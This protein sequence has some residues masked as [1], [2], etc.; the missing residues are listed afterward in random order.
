MSISTEAPRRGAAA[1]E[2]PAGRWR[3]VDIVVA[4]VIAVA[5]GAVFQVWNLAWEGARPA[6]LFFP[7]CRAPCTGSG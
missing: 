4:A 2:L 7:P 1:T 3:T 6:F 5:F